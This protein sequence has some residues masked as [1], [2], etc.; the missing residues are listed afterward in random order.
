VRLVEAMLAET[1][2]T[3]MAHA[4]TAEVIW[5]KNILNKRQQG[6]GVDLKMK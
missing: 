6:S 4:A 5:N 1:H 3:E 2:M